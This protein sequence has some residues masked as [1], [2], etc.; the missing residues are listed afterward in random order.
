MISISAKE[1]GIGLVSTPFRQN[2]LAFVSIFLLLTLYFIAVP[3]FHGISPEDV[4]DGRKYLYMADGNIGSFHIAPFCWRIGTPF[5]AWVSPLPDPLDFQV[6]GFLSL[7][8]SVYIGFKIAK[9][10]SGRFDIALAAALWLATTGVVFHRSAGWMALVDPLSIL[11][12]SLALWFSFRAKPWAFIVVVVLGVLFKESALAAAPIYYLVNARKVIDFRTILPSLIGGIAA[13]ALHVFVRNS[14]PAMNGIAGYE[15]Q[16]DPDL[17]LAGGVYD[18]SNLWNQIGISRLHRIWELP[19]LWGQAYGLMSILIVL[20]IY[21]KPTVLKILLPLT[22]LLSLQLF[23]ASDTHRLLS[24]G[25]PFMIVAIV[26]AISRIVDSSHRAIVFMIVL[27]IVIVGLR[28]VTIKPLYN[29]P[30]LIFLLESNLF[31]AS[32]LLSNWLSATSARQFQRDAE[33]AEK[34]VK[35]YF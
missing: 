33:I 10:L 21:L 20:G 12:F 8:I 35:E 6:L 15:A 27:P 25:F 28:I 29:Y 22:A 30:A 17:L 34:S 4:L 5:L 23:F 14:I 31:M 11:V 26:P 18:A 16:L 2:L 3:L 7:L 9:L 1:R 32:L 24:V 13:L 19:I